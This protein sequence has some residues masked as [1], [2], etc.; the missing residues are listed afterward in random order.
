MLSSLATVF[1]NLVRPEVP[2]PPHGDFDHA[3]W[4]QENRTWVVRSDAE[5]REAA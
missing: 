5:E 4:D 2:P 1:K 3:H